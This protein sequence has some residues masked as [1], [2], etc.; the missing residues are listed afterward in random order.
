MFN[1]RC[2][3]ISFFPPDLFWK[4]EKDTIASLPHLSFFRN[5]YVL[6][7]VMLSE[8]LNHVISLSKSS[9][10]QYTKLH[11]WPP[12]TRFIHCNALLMEFHFQLLSII[13][14]SQNHVRLGNKTNQC[15]LHLRKMILCIPLWLWIKLFAWWLFLHRW[16]DNLHSRRGFRHTQWNRS[17]TYCRCCQTL[18][19]N[20]NLSVHNGGEFNIALFGLQIFDNFAVVFAA[21]HLMC[22]FAVASVGIG[23]TPIL[24]DGDGS[25]EST[26]ISGVSWFSVFFGC[27]W[28]YQILP[29]V[30]VRGLM[31]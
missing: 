7:Y 28:Q 6:K 31:L 9:N 27:R 8:K 11:H 14:L 15:F 19:A 18:N 26:I 21:F 13:R 16:A 25:S 24:A 4:K 20:R 23:T 1:L 2:T 3:T 17:G 5:L 30:G 12:L 22:R 10:Q 29:S